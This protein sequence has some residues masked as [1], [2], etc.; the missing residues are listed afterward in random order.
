MQRKK[1]IVS[2]YYSHLFCLSVRDVEHGNVYITPQKHLKNLYF[3]FTKHY[4]KIS[5]PKTKET[6][7]F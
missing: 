6:L 7:I 4:K 5:E 1:K 3:R 2:V